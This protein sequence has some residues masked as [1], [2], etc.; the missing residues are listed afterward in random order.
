MKED[1]HQSRSAWPAGD[2]LSEWIYGGIDGSVTTFAVVAGAAGAGLDSVI[3]LILGFANLIADGFSMSVGAYLSAKSERENYQKH[4]AV[5][6]W[7]IQHKRESEI[8]EVREIYEAKGFSE[9]LLSQIVNHI[10]SDEE[11]WLDEM[12]KNELEMIP[13]DRSPVSIGLATFGAFNIVGFIPL[14]VY[15]IDFFAPL[16]FNV[17]LA[18][19]ILTLLAFFLIGWGKSRITGTSTLKSAAETV[20][21]GAGAAALAYLAGDLLERIFTA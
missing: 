1:I 8:A 17:F 21:L 11:L 9:P 10:T 15:L 2:Y 4:K 7:E 16:P 19:G 5:E 20:G 14:S 3:V 12:M 13:D 6:V 18:S